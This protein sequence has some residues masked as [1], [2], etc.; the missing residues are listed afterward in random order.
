ML[1]K[2]IHLKSQSN[3]ATETSLFCEVWRI[4]NLSLK[5][6]KTYTRIGY[7]SCEDTGDMAVG[8]PDTPELPAQLTN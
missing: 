2:D 1:L 6:K 5:I 7:V 3:F 8:R 4:K